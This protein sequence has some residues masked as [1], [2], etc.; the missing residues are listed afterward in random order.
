[1]LTFQYYLLGFLDTVAGHFMLVSYLLAVTDEQ[2]VWSRLKK[3]P[4]LSLSPVIAFLLSLGL[5]AVL[6]VGILRYFIISFV[7]LVM[8]S[9]CVTWAWRW[10]IWRAF[11][12]VCMAG[13]L[14]VAATALVQVLFLMFPSGL[15]LDAAAM[16]AALL[17]SAAS[18]AMLKRLHFGTWFRLLLEDQANLRRTAAL[19]FALEISME[20]FLILQNGVRGQYLAAYYSLAVVL[21]LLMIGL[22]VYLAHRFDDSRLLQAQR[23]II[24]QQQIYE[25]S[26]EDIRREIRSFRHDYKNLLA[27]LP[28]QTQEGAQDV[29]C[30]TLPEL[31]ADFDRHLGEK[32]RLSVQIGNLRIPQIRSL[33][34]CKLTDM[35]NKGVECRLEVLYPVERIS[36]NV[37][38]F[39]RCLGVLTDNAIEAA[40]DVQQ[41][42]VEIVLL[43]QGGS[44]FLRVA[45][46]YTNVIDPGKLWENG[47][48]TKGPGRGLG[49]S[50]YRHILEG[51]PNAT[52]CTSWENHVFVQELTLEDRT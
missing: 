30:A 27:G 17:F 46:P 5:S 26:L 32:I 25:Q 4:P 51:Y 49:L 35:G 43:A 11:S 34:L 7:T 14:Q 36:I 23:D 2:A 24:I 31:D 10:D 9:L 37:W 21:V 40:Q 15:K 44:V 19:I 12:A 41:P 29:L 39:V 1:M 16:A 28:L 38:D 18:A 6:E 52:V 48:S 47:W 42:W 22:I 33:L 45:N 50:G 3:L 8:C 13:I 20:T